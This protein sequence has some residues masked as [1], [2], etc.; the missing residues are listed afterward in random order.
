[1][2]SFGCP[3]NCSF[4]GNEQLRTLNKL[5]IQRRSIEGCLSELQHLQSKDFQNIE[6]RWRV[7]VPFNEND[8]EDYKK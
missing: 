1:M 4:C 3:F 8:L 5:N 2:T 6:N 7:H